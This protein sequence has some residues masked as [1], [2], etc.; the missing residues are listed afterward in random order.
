MLFSIHPIPSPKTL[1]PVP[2]SSDLAANKGKEAKKSCMKAIPGPS[3]PTPIQAIPAVDP[4][5]ATTTAALTGTV[6]PAP[7][8]SPP[9]PCLLPT[10]M[11][12]PTFA[13]NAKVRERKQT[14]VQFARADSPL[15]PPPP[16]PMLDD[17]HVQ[18]LK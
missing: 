16:P 12:K 13:P 14:N 6:S 8:P 15:G 7:S 5:A 11:N 10:I 1:V 3:V 17:G 18:G 2:T 9:D 4:P